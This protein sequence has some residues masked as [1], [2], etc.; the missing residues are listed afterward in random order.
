MLLNVI[1]MTECLLVQLIVGHTL[2]CHLSLLLCVECLRYQ[3]CSDGDEVCFL[4]DSKTEKTS[5][6]L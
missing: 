4:R 5:N 1:T 6:G 3:L 2:N